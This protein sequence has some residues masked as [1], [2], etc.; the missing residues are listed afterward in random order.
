MN[1]WKVTTVNPEVPFGA[2]SLGAWEMM[3]EVLTRDWQRSSQV[4]APVFTSDL[5]KGH[6]AKLSW[7]LHSNYIK[8][9]CPGISPA[10]LRVQCWKQSWGEKELRK[11]VSSRGSVCLSLSF[12]SLSLQISPQAGLS[13]FP[14]KP[15]RSAA[16]P[17]QELWVSSL[18]ELFIFTLLPSHRVCAKTHL[19]VSCPWN[20]GSERHYISYKA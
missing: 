14:S 11:V 5:P 10:G 1:W 12:L 13:F 2:C 4:I 19:G 15:H 3:M 6:N 8:K 18:C 9:M 20:K 16:F 7:S 17:P